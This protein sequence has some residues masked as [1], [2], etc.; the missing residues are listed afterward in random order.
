LVIQQK[1]GRTHVATAL[2]QK[3][4]AIHVGR[5]VIHQQ[6]TEK[7]RILERGKS[8]VDGKQLIKDM[9]RSRR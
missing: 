3:E 8:A 2:Q 1:K 7:A 9:F 4:F 6:I 5:R